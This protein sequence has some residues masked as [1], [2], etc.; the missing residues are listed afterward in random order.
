VLAIRAAQ[1]LSCHPVLQKP[2]DLDDI[3]ETVRRRV[4]RVSRCVA[5]ESLVP[6]AKSMVSANSVTV[7]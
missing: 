6:V 1:W 4:N 2:Y 7:V 3:V 5:E